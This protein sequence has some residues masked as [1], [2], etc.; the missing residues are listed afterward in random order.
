MT[1]NKS[2]PIA[3][4]GIA[5][6]FTV[7]LR[8]QSIHFN[9]TDGTNASYNLEDVRKITFDAD[10]M[11]LHLL[12]GSVYG[13]NVSTIGV[14]QYNE[15]SLN[16]QEWL[17]TAN[18]WEVV[19][20]PNPTSTNLNVRYNLPKED[21]LTITLFDMQ[22]NLIFKKNLGKQVSGKHQETLDL[23]SISQGTYVCRISGQQNTITKTVIKN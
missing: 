1:K 2:K 21:E 7:G 15:S 8:A 6:L 9:Y 4:L 23:N 13:W 22:G 10:L 12:D 5:M 14:Y 20:F 16:V 18:A 11:N 19:I 3:L 17:S